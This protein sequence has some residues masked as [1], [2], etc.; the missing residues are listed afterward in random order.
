NDT[1]ISPFMTGP[2]LIALYQAKARGYTVDDQVVTRALD[3]L[4]GARTSEGTYAYSGTPS[5]PTEMPGSSAR[6]SAAEVALHL[7][8]RADDSHLRVAIAGFTRSW[9]FLQERK[10][11]Q[12]THVGPYGIAPYYFFFGHTYAALAI[13]RLPAAERGM[14][15]DEVRRLLWETRESDGGWN[16]RIFPRSKSYGTAMSLIAITAPSRPPLVAW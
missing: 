10:S 9:E 12:G 8:G 2:T 15:R 16:D 3:A 4:E 11:Q 13:E 14:W 7:A 5:G 1:R 6:S